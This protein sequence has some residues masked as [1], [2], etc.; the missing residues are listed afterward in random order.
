MIRIE[1]Q[2]MRKCSRSNINVLFYYLSRQAHASADFQAIATRIN[3]IDDGVRALAIPANRA[4]PNLRAALYSVLRKT[5][6]I[7]MHQ[8]QKFEPM[9]AKRLQYWP[10]VN[11]IRE[12]ERLDR[13]GIPAPMWTEIKPNTVIDPDEWGPYVVV[14]PA[15][16]K[17]CAFVLVRKSGRVRY[18]A[19]SEYPTNHLGREGPMIAQKFVYTGLWPTAYRVVTFLGRAVAAIRYDGRREIPPLTTEYGFNE[20]GGRSIVAAARGCKITCISDTEIIELA[21]R[22]H[23]IAFPEVPSLGLDIIRHEATGALYVME[24]NVRG[25]GFLLYSGEGQQMCREFGLNFHAQFDAIEVMTRSTLDY[26]KVFRN[27]I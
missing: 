15:V 1:S 3:S 11:K 2:V 6:S 8:P 16:G 13:A 24:C 21:E 12:F 14:K 26:V 25:M 19:Q 17:K 9:I 27:G 22:T 4:I 7:E 10:T 23:R 5:I 18:R 20:N